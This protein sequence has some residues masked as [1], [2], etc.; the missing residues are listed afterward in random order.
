[1]LMSKKQYMGPSSL[2]IFKKGCHYKTKY[3]LQAIN[4][5]KRQYTK[6]PLDG[7]IAL[8]YISG[9]GLRN[10]LYALSLSTEDSPGQKSLLLEECNHDMPFPTHWPCFSGPL[11]DGLRRCQNTETTAQAAQ[12]EAFKCNV[13]IREWVETVTDLTLSLSNGSRTIS[14]S[15]QC[16]LFLRINSAVWQ[17]KTFPGN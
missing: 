11:W 10:S 8:E 5:F 2:Y 7:G 16:A 1:M 15:E 4:V 9:P 13:Y 3:F 12:K 14:A 6:R 17:E